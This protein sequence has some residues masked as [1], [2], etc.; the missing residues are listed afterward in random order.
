MYKKLL[1]VAAVAGAAFFTMGA[2]AADV[3]II[4]GSFSQP[5]YVFLKKDFHG[6]DNKIPPRP[7]KREQRRREEA[8]RPAPA[9]AHNPGHD[10]KKHDRQHFGLIDVNLGGSKKRDRSEE[11]HV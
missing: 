2:E 8:R 11:P 9:P 7:D 10:L 6:P 5:A 3:Q 1:C 4:D